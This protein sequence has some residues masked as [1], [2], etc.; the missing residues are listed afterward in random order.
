MRFGAFSFNMPKSTG[1]CFVFYDNICALCRSRNEKITPVV[2]A[3]GLSTGV[4]SKWRNG[5]T[6]D[7]KTLVKIA[8]YF[9]VTVE[10]LL[11]DQPDRKEKS[12]TE[13]GE[14]E[15]IRLFAQSL[16]DLTEDELRQV[17]NYAEFLR[18]QRNS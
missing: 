4:I 11:S 18:K 2:K 13:V 1:V 10:S 15:D 5:A 8:D 17:L 6:P 12:P 14:D 7:S 9:G 16:S 3:I